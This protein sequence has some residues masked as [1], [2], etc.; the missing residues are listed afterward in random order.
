MVSPLYWVETFLS[1]LVAGWDGYVTTLRQHVCVAKYLHTALENSDWTVVNDSALAVV[2][3]YDR[4]RANGQSATY[5]A[6]IAEH[7]KASG[8]AWLTTTSLSNYG[9][10]LRACV[11]N[12]RSTREDVDALISAL[13]D[14]RQEIPNI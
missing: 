2:C 12:H 3:F 11:T 7:V 6:A 8:R 5:L 10:V 9:P 14:A 1:L 4:S 13:N